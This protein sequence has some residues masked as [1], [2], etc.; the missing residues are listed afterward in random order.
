MRSKKIYS[1]RL[2]RRRQFRPTLETLERRELLSGDAFWSGFAG[3]SQ[4]TGISPVTSQPLD[5]IRWQTPVDLNPQ[6]SFGELLI[7]YGEIMITN[8]NTVIVPVKVGATDG[9]RLDAHNGRDGSMLWTQSTDY[10]LPTHDWTPSFP[11]VLTPSGRV[12]FAGPGGTVY[13]RDNVDS[14]NGAT[15][16]IAFFGPLS[17]YL[18]NKPAYDSSVF[19]DTPLTSDSHGDIFFG[20]RVEGFS[21]LSIGSQSGFARIDPNGNGT[22]IGV[23]DATGDPR[24]TRDSHN[25][26]PVL[27]NDES[28]IYVEAKDTFVYSYAYLIALNSTTLASEHQVLLHDPRDNNANTTGTLDNGSASP[29]VAPDG[30]IFFGVFGN[31]DNGSRGFTLHFS[32]DLSTEMTP[33][34]FG[35]DDTIS[36]V[37]A[38]MVPSY[39][40]TSSYLIFTKYNNYAGAD[41]GDGV[42]R[43]AI[44][45]PNATMVDPHP[46]SDGLL[47]MNVVESIVGPT[48]DPNFR[49]F[50]PNAVREWCINTAAVD[51]ATDS[52]LGNSEDGNLYRWDLRTDTLSES[53]P[54]SAA[55]GQA[56]TPTAIGPDGTVYAI[57]D[58]KLFA[59]GQFLSRI[60]VEALPPS[61]V[62]GQPVTL[63]ASVRGSGPALTGTVQFFDGSTALGAAPVDST[64]H[65]VL[66][67]S[68]L[69]VGTHSISAFYSGDA[70]HL[71]ARTLS[72]ATAIVGMNSSD[73]ALKVFVAR[74]VFSSPVTL[75]ATVTGHAT[76]LAV[77]SGT[78]TFFDGTTPIG[79]AAVDFFSGQ[80][81]FTTFSLGVGAHSIT[82]SFSGNIDYTA[83]TSAAVSQ[84]IVADSTSTGLSASPNPSS[85]GQ[86]VTLTA[87]VVANLPGFGIPTGTV[88]FQ[89][90][91][92]ILGTGTLDSTGHVSITIATLPA[93]SLTIS[94]VY[95]G[96]GN[97]LSSTGRTLQRVNRLPVSERLTSSAN[98]STAGQTVTFTA[99]VSSASGTPTG[100]V[101]FLDSGNILGVVPLDSSGTATLST[102]ALTVGSH[103]ITAVY[104]GSSIFSGT[105]ANL[106]QVVNPTANVVSRASVANGVSFSRLRSDLSEAG[107]NPSPSGRTTFAPEAD[108]LVSSS[109]PVAAVL[110]ADIVDRIFGSQ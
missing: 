42:N 27:S 13:F 79:S 36:I 61:T 109:K 40:G 92:G 63:N 62:F 59:V 101:T 39:T 57:N 35:W 90:S 82:A 30:S 38:S 11:A 64:G 32:A 21:P 54:L 86:S 10:I 97:F 1:A 7:H 108:S 80:A 23:T 18:A 107:N 96:D 110:D 48:P 66:V 103:K 55:L 25:V 77:T 106:A 89:T 9:F 6:F 67:V 88:T 68:S 8:A 102:S 28:T 26:A 19:I 50:F 44:L 51:P 60:K 31:P 43:I 24:I 16:Q 100:N 75:V 58:A 5:T 87:T 69:G 72:A 99:V 56:Y 12:Y 73:V 46:S 4:H 105:S 22:F 52:V 91:A 104:G 20:F 74:D 3:N 47:V 45:D 15:G 85:V 93:G 78:V 95:A 34:A 53:M 76:G 81:Q 41:D 17:T 70:T 98:P 2:S 65:A 37:P 84:P 33:G 29:V 71:D 83:G 94:A 49:P 14:A